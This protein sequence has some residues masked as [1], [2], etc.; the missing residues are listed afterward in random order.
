MSA[1]FNVRILFYPVVALSIVTLIAVG[2]TLYVSGFTV[3]NSLLN[4]SLGQA[5]TSR[6]GLHYHVDSLRFGCLQQGCSGEISVGA[7]D[8]ALATPEIFR[9]QLNSAEWTRQTPII[10]HH[11]EIR[12]GPLP[13][14]ISLDSLEIDSR[15]GSYGSKRCSNSSNWR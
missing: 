8:L 12:S 9:I 13:P 6:Y 14:L 15:S 11:L 1:R 2:V 4:S 7:L 3:P 10:A 5:I